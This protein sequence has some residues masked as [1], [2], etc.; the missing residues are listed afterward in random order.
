MIQLEMF[1]DIAVAIEIAKIRQSTESVR[2]SVYARIHELQK[3]VWE[4]KEKI[5]SKENKAG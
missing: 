1:P 4:L 5:E 2:K 3:E